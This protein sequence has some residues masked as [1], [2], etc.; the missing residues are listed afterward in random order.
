[1]T[2]EDRIKHFDGVFLTM[3]GGEDV[4][5]MLV[6]H[7]RRESYRT[8]AD[9]HGVSHMTVRQWVTQAK[10]AIRRAGLDTTDIEARVAKQESPIGPAAPAGR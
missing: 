7:Y 3:I 10:A 5:D 1:M 9:K 2:N 4:W 6:D 8:I